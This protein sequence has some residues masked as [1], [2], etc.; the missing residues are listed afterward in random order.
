V[1]D[2]AF[3]AMPDSSNLSRE[4]T[5]RRNASCGYRPGRKNSAGLQRRGDFLST[6]IPDNGNLSVLH[7]YPRI[8][9]TLTNSS[10]NPS[11]PTPQSNQSG[12]Q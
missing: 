12:D 10:L 4:T 6:G 8:G 1:A 5:S 9:E 11:L 2:L 7:K 3:P